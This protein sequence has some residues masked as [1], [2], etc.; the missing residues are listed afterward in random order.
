MAFQRT[1]VGSTYN[2]L[3]SQY[4]IVHRFGLDTD[5]V[6]NKYLKKYNSDASTSNLIKVFYCM[7]ERVHEANSKY[8]S[9]IRT[10]KLRRSLINAKEMLL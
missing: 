7:V 6:I 5:T 9:C 3:V 10:A 8:S 1:L 4:R 2:P